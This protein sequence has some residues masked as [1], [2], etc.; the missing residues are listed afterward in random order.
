MIFYAEKSAIDSSLN[1]KSER[2]IIFSRWRGILIH[3]IFVLNFPFVPD[4]GAKFEIAEIELIWKTMG[5]DVETCTNDVQTIK[6]CP[7]FKF[8]SHGA[9]FFSAL[10][11]IPW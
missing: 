1:T 6:T 3:R 11:T 2:C 10:E 7:G 4:L 9:A 5:Y 8:P